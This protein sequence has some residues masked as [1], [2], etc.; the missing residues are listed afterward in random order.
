VALFVAR[1][2][3]PH[4][5]K[6]FVVIFVMSEGFCFSAP[7]AWLSNEVTST[8][9]PCNAGVSQRP[10]GVLGSPYP[11]NF[12]DRLDALWLFA[13]RPVIGPYFFKI[14]IPIGCGIIFVALLALI[15]MAV[16]HSMMGV[17]LTQR[18]DGVA[19][20]TGFHERP[21]KAHHTRFD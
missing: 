9:C 15:D 16:S 17:K 2:A 7:N 6:R 18:L 11:R 12:C 5:V 21:L 4:N 13:T 1:L 20:K 19:L 14:F 10:A 8:N 3:K